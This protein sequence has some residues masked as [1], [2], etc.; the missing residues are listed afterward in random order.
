MSDVIAIEPKTGRFW[1]IE[2]KVGKD[3]QSFEQQCF[4]TDV[5]KR[6]GVYL[7]VKSLDDLIAAV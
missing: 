2:I 6:G 4:E 3:R 1:G 7:I 5:K